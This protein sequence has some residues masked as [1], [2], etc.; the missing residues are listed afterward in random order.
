MEEDISRLEQELM[1]SGGGTPPPARRATASK[2]MK[3]AGGPSYNLNNVDKSGRIA[4]RDASPDV[5]AGRDRKTLE[6]LVKTQKRLLKEL[7]D[8]KKEEEEL[9]EEDRKYYTQPHF[10]RAEGRIADA[11][12]RSSKCWRL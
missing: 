1:G 10:M 6:V 8:E 7:E 4:K 9:L 3:R 12:R 5:L 11:S 2:R